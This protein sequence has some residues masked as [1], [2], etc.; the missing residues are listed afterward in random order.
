MGFRR[1]GEHEDGALAPKEELVA[2][3]TGASYG[4]RIIDLSSE[5]SLGMRAFAD[6]GSA[7]IKDQAPD[8][9][10][11]HRSTQPSSH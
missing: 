1:P 6:Y 3:S 10:V 11:W 7:F 5:T 8:R 9:Y 4:V 2:L